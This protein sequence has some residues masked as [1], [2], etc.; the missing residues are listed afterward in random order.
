MVS[1]EVVLSNPVEQVFVHFNDLTHEVL[2]VDYL[3]L[4]ARWRFLLFCPFPDADAL[5]DNYYDFQL[6]F[7][8]EKDSNT[9]S[10]VL[11]QVIKAEIGEGREALEV[12]KTSEVKAEGKV[13]DSTKGNPETVPIDEDQR[14]LFVGGLAQVFSMPV[15]YYRTTYFISGGQRCRRERIFW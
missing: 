4:T 9:F 14:K 11:M 3:E 2:D 1:E 8:S 10:L 6:M 13:E 12:S 15:Q 7:S 5:I